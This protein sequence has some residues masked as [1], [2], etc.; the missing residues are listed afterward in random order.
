[1]TFD[2]RAEPISS[3]ER[4]NPGCHSI[5]AAIP[6]GTR[7][8]QPP[9]SGSGRRGASRAA[10][11]STAA[12]RCRRRR[13][14]ARRA[15]RSCRARRRSAT[16]RGV[17]S[18]VPEPGSYRRPGALGSARSSRRSAPST[19]QNDCTSSVSDS[20]TGVPSRPRHV[21][22]LV[23]RR[24]QEDRSRGLGRHV[25]RRRRR[26][27]VRSSSPARWRSTTARVGRRCEDGCDD[28]D[29]V[30][31]HAG[32]VVVAGPGRPVR[33]GRGGSWAIACTGMI[34]SARRRRRGGS[35]AP[36]PV[37]GRCRQLLTQLSRQLPT[38]PVRR[39][40]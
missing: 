39:A 13:R 29:A 23:R 15:P 5:W 19:T 16:R 37:E 35:P 38:V 31:D 21:P 8:D 32:E 24:R 2:R 17:V 20:S 25:R 33:V 4:P 28:R 9:R 27:T 6:C 7:K 22:D 26:S 10:H 12:T 40:K 3:V 14:G 36:S 11:A 1:M 18:T 34:G 30:R